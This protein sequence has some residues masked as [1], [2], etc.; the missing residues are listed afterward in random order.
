MYILFKL[1]VIKSHFNDF[2]INSLTHTLVTSSQ[3]LDAIFS[4]I[5]DADKDLSIGYDQIF[6]LMQRKAE[7]EGKDADETWIESCTTV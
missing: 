2:A 3:T 6:A 5:A 1:L 7:A 4:K